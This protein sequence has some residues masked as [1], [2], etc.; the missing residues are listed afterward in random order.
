MGKITTQERYGLFK[1]TL[2]HCGLFLLNLSDEDIAYHIFEEFDGDCISFLD[3]K[4]LDRLKLSG[5]ITSEIVDMA[6]ELASKFR[7]LENT[8][9]WNVCSVRETERWRAIMEL[10]DRIKTELT[11]LVDRTSCFDWFNRKVYRLFNAENGRGTGYL[12]EYM[13]HPTVVKSIAIG[14]QRNETYDPIGPGSLT[15][16]YK[17]GEQHSFACYTDTVFSGQ[18]GITVSDDGER[19]YVISDVK[20]L[21]CYDKHGNV[22]WK[23]RYTSAGQVYPHR[24]GTLTCVTGTHLILLD[25]NG[26]PIKKRVKFD[27][28]DCEMSE[29]TIGILSSENVVAVIDVQTLEPILKI[30]LSKLNID[31]FRD[32]IEAGEYYVLQGCERIGIFDLP[33]GKRDIREKEVIYL[34][35][36][37]GDILRKIEN[38]TWT[39]ASRAYVDRETNE[40]VLYAQYKH[41]TNTTYR[42]AID[43]DSR[44]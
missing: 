8:E 26:K 28:V 2:E 1:Q 36:N 18:H 22:I 23:T 44:R 21:W 27:G 20:G 42:I 4:N 19:I 34:L 3:E 24:D 41:H 15:V 25:E 32:I 29:K 31:R 16:Y 10:S 12:T 5:K 33:N 39:Y 7:S 30:S 11:Q 6:L 38:P 14:V 17:K 37:N 35:S 40:V 43:E 9:L 13:N